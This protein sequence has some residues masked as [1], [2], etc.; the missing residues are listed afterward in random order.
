M[1]AEQ[2]GSHLDRIILPDCEC[3][4]VEVIGQKAEAR[5]V[6]GPTKA[7]R[8]ELFDGYLE[9]IA[10]FRAVDIDG[11]RDRIDLGKIELGNVADG[12][13]RRNLPAG[14]IETLEE[15]G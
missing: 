14:G 2:G 12:A 3:R 6:R 1:F 5:N 9:R 7:R 11:P 15:D 8:L 4:F 13:L 10:G